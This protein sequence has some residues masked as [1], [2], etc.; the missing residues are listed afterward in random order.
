MRTKFFFYSLLVAFTFSSAV[1]SQPQPPSTREKLK[2]LKK[3]LELS[4]TQSKQ[5]ETILKTTEAKMD[6]L[7]EKMEDARDDAMDAM[8]SIIE[9]EDK[10]IVKVLDESQKEKY[11][12]MK[13]EMEENRPQKGDHPEPPGDKR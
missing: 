1:Y 10:E 12:E 9:T 8:D 6:S 7:K 5:I 11:V 2:Q 4:E 3:T 13:K